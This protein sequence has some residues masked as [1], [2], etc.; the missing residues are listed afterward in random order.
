MRR[1]T[2]PK[3]YHALYATAPQEL[4][5]RF[6]PGTQPMVSTTYARAT[7]WDLAAATFHAFGHTNIRPGELKTPSGTPVLA[8]DLT[9]A[10]HTAGAP[11]EGEL[12]YN[13]R[14]GGELILARIV[15]GKT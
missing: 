8:N 6:F 10:L 2:A 12:V 1:A 3:L 7:Y 14:F 11:S 13:P 5:D 9:R 4:V 15:D